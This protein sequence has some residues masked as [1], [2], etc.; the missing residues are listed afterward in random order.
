M[1][2]KNNK[3]AVIFWSSGMFLSLNPP[4]GRSLA[5]ARMGGPSDPSPTD[6]GWVFDQRSPYSCPGIMR[7]R[8]RGHVPAGGLCRPAL[9]GPAPGRRFL[10]EQTG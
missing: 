9:P 5:L 2:E 3:N 4:D 10:H 6:G 8:V 7:C 1:S